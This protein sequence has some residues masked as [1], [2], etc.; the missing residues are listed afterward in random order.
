MKL[1]SK[2][3]SLFLYVKNRND[4]EDRFD[5]MSISEFLYLME[6]TYD[7]RI[8]QRYKGLGEN[9]AEVLFA[10]TLNPKTRKLV[11]FTIDDMKKTLEVFHLLHA[12][13][14]EVRQLRRDIL[15]E[16]NISYMDLDN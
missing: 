2:N 11:R 13:N 4:D 16:C 5:R 1:L 14:A 12:G 8:L 7:V 6:K 15:K 10:S 3:E 9:D